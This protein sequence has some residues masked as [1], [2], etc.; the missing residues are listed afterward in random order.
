MSYAKIRSRESFPGSPT[1]TASRPS[2]SLSPLRKP[3]DRSPRLVAQRRQLERLFRAGSDR[4]HAPTAA[5]LLMLQRLIG[6]RAARRLL[7]AKDSTLSFPA[8]NDGVQPA[9]SRRA[10]NEDNRLPFSNRG[11]AGFRLIQ[12]EWVPHPTTYK[13]PLLEHRAAVD[14][15]RDELNERVQNAYQ[16]ALHWRTL[17]R[18]DDPLVR[19]WVE[20]AEEYARNPDVEPSLIHARFGYAIE[21]LACQGLNNTELHGL[22]I[23]TQVGHGHTRP[24]VVL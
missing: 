24:D 19:L 15:T 20:A 10:R 1:R 6:N 16:Q 21:S 9:I 11:T 13:G 23:A 22:A 3:A 14:R 12:R 2:R 8:T 7:P 4:Q 18:N 17:G 5:D